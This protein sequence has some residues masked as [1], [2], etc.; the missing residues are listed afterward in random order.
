M[1]ALTDAQE[2][3]RLRAT[4]TSWERLPVTAECP[5]CGLE[6][7]LVGARRAV[8]KHGPADSPCLGGGAAA[9]VDG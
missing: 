6:Y 7:R 8:P 9:A 5:V 2:G 4:V 1:T 3:T